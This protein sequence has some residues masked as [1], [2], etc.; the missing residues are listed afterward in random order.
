M[1]NCKSEKI[2]DIPEEM[3]KTMNEGRVFNIVRLLNEM[4]ARFDVEYEGIR[5]TSTNKMDKL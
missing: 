1:D 2:K 3:T 5:Y 4:G